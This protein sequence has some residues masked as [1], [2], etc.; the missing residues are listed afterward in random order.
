MSH[1]EIDSETEEARHN[2]DLTAA[3]RTLDRLTDISFVT[4]LA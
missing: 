4:T 2:T 3:E 1:G